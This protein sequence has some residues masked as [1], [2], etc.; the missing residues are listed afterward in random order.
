MV[1]W[2]W[3]RHV[4][5]PRVILALPILACLWKKTTLAEMMFNVIG[6]FLRAIASLSPVKVAVWFGMVRYKPL[7]SHESTAIKDTDSMSFGICTL[8]ADDLQI[9]PNLN[10][11][12]PN[13]FLSFCIVNKGVPFGAMTH[14]IMSSY[15][16]SQFV[17]HSQYA[18]ILQYTHS[19]NWWW[20]KDCVYSMGLEHV[21][22]DKV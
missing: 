8:W 14:G 19:W 9:C 22:Y 11:I 21:M 17:N 15:Q 1:I 18:Y 2:L 10:I 13:Y 6:V 12:Y 4:W 5:W 3:T 20:R 16:A 7:W